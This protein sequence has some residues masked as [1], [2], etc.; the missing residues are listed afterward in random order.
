MRLSLA[1]SRHILI[2]VSRECHNSGSQLMPSKMG[3]VWSEQKD[4]E[5]NGENMLLDA[6]MFAASTLCGL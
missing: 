3:T 2:V 4:H 1:I 5:E 6:C